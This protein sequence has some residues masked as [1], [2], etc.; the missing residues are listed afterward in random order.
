MM[1]HM[2]QAAA[3][4][5][6]WKVIGGRHSP[7]A[8]SSPRPL[9]GAPS[10]RIQRSHGPA[11][12]DRPLLEDLLLLTSSTDAQ[13]LPS[14][15]RTPRLVGSAGVPWLLRRGIL[16][17]SGPAT[18]R[19]SGRALQPRIGESLPRPAHQQPEGHVH[20]ACVQGHIFATQGHKMR[21]CIHNST[22]SQ[23]PKFQ[24]SKVRMVTSLQ[25]FQSE[26]HAALG[27]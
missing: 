18:P 8:P 22:S 16:H 15:S 1:D 12:L 9:W 5:T 25:V 13:H 4:R 19:T 17:W 2:G 26:L 10:T 23:S 27:I 21:P 6:I 7:D 24:S 20:D 11:A 14:R 3:Q